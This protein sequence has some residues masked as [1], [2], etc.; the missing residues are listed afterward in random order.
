MNK[1]TERL[2]AILS[3]SFILKV[4]AP[5]AKKNCLVQKEQ[6]KK[7]NLNENPLSKQKKSPCKDLILAYYKLFI[8]ENVIASLRC[9]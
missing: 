8:A 4:L 7:I 5:Q 2:K 3:V 9:Q 1:E 6:S